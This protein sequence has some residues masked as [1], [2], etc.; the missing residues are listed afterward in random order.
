MGPA[1][2]KQKAQT[3][4]GVSFMALSAEEA[5]VNTKVDELMAAWEALAK[6]GSD[7]DKKFLVPVQDLKGDH[8]DTRYGQDANVT[9]LATGKRYVVELPDSTNGHVPLRVGPHPH[10][11]KITNS[12]GDLTA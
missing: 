2:E 9:F 7:K 4:E 8:Q 12:A 11:F 5:A 1:P 6:A 3:P 10:F